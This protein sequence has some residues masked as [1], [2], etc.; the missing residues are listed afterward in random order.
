MNYFDC[1]VLLNDGRGPAISPYDVTVSF[2]R[3]RIEIKIEVENQ[4]LD[5]CA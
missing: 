4:G 3:H 2:D 1:I 5:R